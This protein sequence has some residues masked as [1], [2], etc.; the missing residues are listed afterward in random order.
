MMI[1][2]IYCVSLNRLPERRNLMIEL[3]SSFESVFDIYIFDAIDWK[4]FSVEKFNE[5]G[6]FVYDSWKIENSDNYWYKREL[7]MGS[8][9]NLLGHFSIWNH[10]YNNY[11]SALILEDDVHFHRGIEVFIDGL[12]CACNFMDNNV[13][14]I[15]YLNCIPFEKEGFYGTKINDEI[16]KCNMVY[17]SD[18]YIVTQKSARELFSSGIK[19]NLITTDEYIGSTFCE[20]PREDIRNLYKNKKLIAHRLIEN[21]TDQSVSQEGIGTLGMIFNF[22][23]AFIVHKM[24]GDA[25]KDIQDLVESIRYP[26]GAGEAQDH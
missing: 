17:N 14:D 5:E 25:P 9:C 3:L 4:E 2:A 18:S 6:F 16:E 13:C 24:T 11:N 7:K 12:N 23:V 10:I 26:K 15:F 22:A 1:D 19:E 20:H 21:V 8:L